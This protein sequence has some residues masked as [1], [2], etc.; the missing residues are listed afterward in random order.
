MYI[1]YIRVNIYRHIYFHAE[2]QKGGIMVVRDDTGDKRKSPDAKKLVQNNR[3]F[4]KS[5]SIAPHTRLTKL[6]K[7]ESIRANSVSTHWMVVKRRHYYHH[8]H[9]LVIIRESLYIVWYTINV[10]EKIF[11]VRNAM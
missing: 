11:H 9:H 4:K 8:H 10:F 1:I 2:R 6:M 5:F 7:F 3:A